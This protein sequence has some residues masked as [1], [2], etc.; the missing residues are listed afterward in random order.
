MLT[1]IVVTMESLRRQLDRDED[2]EM[3]QGRF[4]PHAVSASAFIGNAIQIETQQY[5]PNCK[6]LI[7]PLTYFPDEIYD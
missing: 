4:P 5:V 1:L 2:Q 6:T 7:N 3:C